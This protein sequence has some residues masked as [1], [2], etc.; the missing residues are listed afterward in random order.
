MVAVA[1]I[2]LLVAISAVIL[3][4]LSGSVVANIL[5]DCVDRRRLRRALYSEIVV[6]YDALKYIAEDLKKD[7]DDNTLTWSDRYFRFKHD[8][9]YLKHD[10]GADAYKYAKETPALFRGLNDVESIDAAYL[11]FSFFDIELEAA[12]IKTTLPVD[13]W[14]QARR[15]R[16]V[17]MTLLKAVEMCFKTSRLDKKMLLKAADSVAS[18][19]KEYLEK[20]LEEP[21][22]E[23]QQPKKEVEPP[24]Y[25]EHFWQFWRPKK[26]ETRGTDDHKTAGDRWLRRSEEEK[27]NRSLLKIAAFPTAFLVIGILGIIFSLPSS[28][29]WFGLIFIAI[30][31]FITVFLVDWVIKYR[32]EQQWA[33]VRSITL[34]AIS[35]LLCDIAARIWEKGDVAWDLLDGISD[36][37]NKLNPNTPRAFEKLADALA[38][39]GQNDFIVDSVLFSA[40]EIVVKNYKDYLWELNQIQLVLTPLVITSSSDQKLIDA[41]IEFDKTHRKFCLGIRAADMVGEAWN[42]GMVELVRSSGKLYGAI[43]DSLTKS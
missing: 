42:P 10:L 5:K 20:L 35:T 33:N 25:R 43:L 6:M 1:Q 26:P 15:L 23:A 34:N 9:G 28:E 17:C 27:M 11:A 4:F 41:L 29:F 16:A 14:D 39:R 2:D 13:P 18:S 24:R 37:R 38:E 7:I 31:I 19:N 32:R 36:G 3:G 30:N 40:S 22:P 21:L 8:Y 12:D